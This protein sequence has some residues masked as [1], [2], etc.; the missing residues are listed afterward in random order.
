MTTVPATRGGRHGRGD[1]ALWRGIAGLAGCAAA[2]GLLAARSPLLAIGFAV[3][4]TFVG[5]VLADVTT[6]FLLF[7]FVAFLEVIPGVGGG[8]SFA[9]VAGLTLLLSWLAATTAANARSRSFVSEH[10]YATGLIV[11]FL[12]WTAASAIWAQDQGTV[13]GAFFRYAPNLLLLPIAFTAV[14]T[15]RDATRFGIVFVG[16]ALISAIYG[17]AS[18]AGAAAG[19][20]LGGA[21]GDPNILAMTLVG[22][23][24]GAAGLALMPGNSK[25][26]RAGAGIAAALCVFATLGTVSRGGMISLGVVLVLAAVLSRHG[27]RS[28]AIALVVIVAAF[29]SVYVLTIAPA[30]V[31]DR[32]TH[33]DGGSGRSDLWKIGWRVVQADPILGVGAGN[34]PIVSVHY[35]LRPGTITRSD[36]IV[37][38]QKVAHN[39]YLEIP[40]ELGIVGLILFLAITGF[41]LR[42]GIRASRRFAEAGDRDMELLALSIVLGAAGMLTANVFISQQFNK[43]LWLLLSIGPAL[44]ALA[45]AEVARTKAET[46]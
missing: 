17:I 28:G 40:A 10:P 4:L 27:R 12:T 43:P 20:R 34:F 3:A 31:R 29:S 8:L 36:L 46:A 1:A 15:R 44:L 26:L 35:V 24:A 32:I 21:G 14:R 25:A 45:N 37:D 6:G 30:Y 13:F 19:D 5:F 38:E 23:T 18:P 11:L 7:T 42:C 33:N 16:A 41:A 22:A 9:K 2:L 39:I